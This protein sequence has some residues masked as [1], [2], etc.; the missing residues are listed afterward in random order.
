MTINRAGKAVTTGEL[1]LS[2]SGMGS[3]SSGRNHSAPDSQDSDIGGDRMTSCENCANVI[4]EVGHMCPNARLGHECEHWRSLF[5]AMEVER[6][7]V[8][9]IGGRR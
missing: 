2:G 7:S 5:L 3:A 4:D 6:L 8:S 9:D 1:P